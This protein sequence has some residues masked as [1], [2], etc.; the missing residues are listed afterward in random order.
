MVYLQLKVGKST[1]VKE[2]WFKDGAEVKKGKHLEWESVWGKTISPCS[3][4]VNKQSEIESGNKNG[5]K[6]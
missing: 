6:L 5:K 1:G 4:G 2:K 3:Q